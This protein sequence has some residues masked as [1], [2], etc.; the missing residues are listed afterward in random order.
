M[1]CGSF[2]SV[3]S[4]DDKLRFAHDIELTLDESEQL[5]FD[6]NYIDAVLLMVRRLKALSLDDKEYAIICAVILFHDGTLAIDHLCAFM[7]Q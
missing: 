5:G 7:E 3:G 2:R 1:I 4:I 6:Q